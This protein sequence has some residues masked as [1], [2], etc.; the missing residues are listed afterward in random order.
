MDNRYK[1]E[2]PELMRGKKVMYV[3]GFGSSAQSGTVRL[4]RQLMPEAVVVAEDLPIHPEEAM[5]LLRR[6]CDE[7]RPDLII[8]SSMGAMYTEML[9]GFDRILVN[10]AFQMGDTMMKHDMLGRQVFMNPRQ[11]GV[12]EFIVTKSLVAEYKAITE[13]CFS[14]VTPEEQTRVYGL[15]G[16]RDP[17]VHTFPLFR[18]HYMQAIPFHGEHQL[19]DSVAVHYLVPVIRW[20]DDRQQGRERPVMYIT[21]DALKDHYGKP[22][23]SM[24]KAYE[25]LLEHYDIYIIAP[26]PT[27]DHPSLTAAQ[28]W[29]EEYLSAPAHDRLILT[30]HPALLYGDYLIA[31]QPSPDFMGTVIELGTDEFKTWEEAIVFFSRLG[32]Q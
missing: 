30:N 9:Y 19:I 22:R 6:M 2:F 10:P 31:T 8:G 28:E 5:A 26:A 20:I 7:E 17:L 1:T 21:L 25:A 24:H 12:Q 18:E 27:N 29:C 11:D 15:F 4:L 3:H 13:Q 16:D 14:H 23:S 32:G